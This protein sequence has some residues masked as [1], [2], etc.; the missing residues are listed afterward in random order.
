MKRSILVDTFTNKTSGNNE[1]TNFREADCN[2]FS[3]I[4]EVVPDVY[5]I[6]CL[7]IYK[8]VHAMEGFS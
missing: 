6:R 4:L 7:C 1:N 5:A 2:V 3:S 8:G